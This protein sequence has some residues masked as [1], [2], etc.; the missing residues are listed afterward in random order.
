MN[1]F[2]ILIVVLGILSGL[3]IGYVILNQIMYFLAIVIHWWE[4]RKA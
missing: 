4:D 1:S 3:Y 2:G